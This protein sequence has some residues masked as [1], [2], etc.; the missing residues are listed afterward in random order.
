VAARI[1]A[2]ERPPRDYGYADRPVREEV[3][4]EITGA[5]GDAAAALTRNSY[6]SLVLNTRDLVFIDI[7]LPQETSGGGLVGALKGLFGKSEADDPASRIRRRVA[8]QTAT[9][10][11]LTIRLYRTFAGF[12]CAVTNR[13]MSP[14]GPESRRLLGE[15]GADPLYVRLC[16]VQQ[17]YRAR[18]TPKYWRCGGRRPPNRFPWDTEAD[19]Q[20]YRA[21][22]REYEAQSARFATCRFVEQFGSQEG[23]AESAALIRLHDELTKSDSG[24]ELA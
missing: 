3:V 13:R 15:F 20:E 6:G 22:E 23:N 19:E 1:A 8:A 16:Q 5:D 24:L 12:R 7:D 9:R 11:D 4:E 2:D 17:S 18:L 21:W 10:P 14:A